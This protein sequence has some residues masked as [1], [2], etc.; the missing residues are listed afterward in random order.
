MKKDWQLR[1]DSSFVTRHSS[2]LPHSPHRYK[3]DNDAA[4]ENQL[5][6]AGSTPLQGH[7]KVSSS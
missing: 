3:E 1:I 2:F 7:G 4:A 6:D 5:P